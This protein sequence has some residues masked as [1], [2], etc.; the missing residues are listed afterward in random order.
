MLDSS[1]KMNGTSAK[2][3]AHDCVVNFYQND[4]EL[5]SFLKFVSD[6]E[7]TFTDIFETLYFKSICEELTLKN[8]TYDDCGTIVNKN[9]N[10]VSSARLTLGNE[11]CHH[12]HFPV[13]WLP[14][15]RN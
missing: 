14:Q 9:L 3:Y 13:S 10:N 5:F 2:D 12:L 7:S 8:I 4:E 11:F 15:L 6:Y 1:Y